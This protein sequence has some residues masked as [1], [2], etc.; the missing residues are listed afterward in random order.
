MSNEIGN[1]SP[2]PNDVA[3]KLKS[4]TTVPSLPS[5][6]LG[7]IENSLDASASQIEVEVSF[8]RGACSVEDNGTGITPVNFHEDGGLGKPCR[9]PHVSSPLDRLTGRRYLQKW[10]CNGL[11]RP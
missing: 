1:I 3:A 4:S 11:S 5:A 7:L 2:L 9:K 8:S 10:W 6:I